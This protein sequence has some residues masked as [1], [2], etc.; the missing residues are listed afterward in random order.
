MTQLKLYQYIQQYIHDD[1]AMNVLYNLIKD[2]AVRYNFDM[3]KNNIIN[4]D[5]RFLG[6]EF[7]VLLTGGL[8]DKL[9]FFSLMLSLKTIILD[10]VYFDCCTD[11]YLIFKPA[12]SE[13]YDWILYADVIRFFSED[14]DFSMVFNLLSNVYYNIATSPDDIQKFKDS[15]VI[16][17]FKNEKKYYQNL[18]AAGVKRKD[19]I[20]DNAFVDS[21]ITTYV[22]DKKVV[23][24]G[25]TAFAYCPNLEKIK[26]E[27]KVKFGLFPIVE[28]QSLKRIVVPGEL[29]SYYKETLPFYSEIISSS[30][31]VEEKH[32]IVN[33]EVVP[34]Q[35]ITPQTEVKQERKIT[36][37]QPIN[38]KLIY[39]IFDKKATSYK[40]FWFLSIIS[41]AKQKGSLSV[42][43]KDILIRWAAIAWPIVFE[44]ELSLGA[45]DQISRYLSMLKKKVN[46]IPAASSK[47]VE[48]ALTQ[49]YSAKGLDAILNP[50]LNNVPYL[51]LSPWI[52]FTNNQDVIEKSNSNEYA[53]P[54]AL[55]DDCIILD[56][57]WLEYI[58]EHYDE[59]CEFTK[60]SFVKYLESYNDKMKLLKLMASGFS[61]IK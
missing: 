47:V 41:I 8:K 6:E 39:N 13:K 60:K 53:C 27:G 49:N 54:Y 17:E 28:C 52:P 25:N 3:S 21:D 5:G 61:L 11:D 24:V 57:D 48:A 32:E 16:P 33:E 50:L 1:Y 15:V 31:I 46:I 36:Q 9:H 18:C 55:H 22:I 51:F 42:P 45:S 23:Y 43:H 34:S 2:A 56:E 10:S 35:T 12:P 19:I 38:T 44:D 26:F 29:V 14:E 4:I 20:S 40:Y 37:H 59:L 58:E 30:D 7:E